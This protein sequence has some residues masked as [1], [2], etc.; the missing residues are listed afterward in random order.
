MKRHYTLIHSQQGFLLFHVVWV[1]LIVFL[2]LHFLLYQYQTAK[3]VADNQLSDIEVETLFQMAYKRVNGEID[4]QEIS[5]PYETSYHF[6][7]GEVKVT[8]QAETNETINIIYAI[9]QTGSDH[10]YQFARYAPKQ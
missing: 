9:K 2:C 4:V 8:F 5:L 6:T 3:I 7:R 10:I 1:I